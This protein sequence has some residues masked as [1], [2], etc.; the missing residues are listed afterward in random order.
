MPSYGSITYTTVSQILDHQYDTVCSLIGAAVTSTTASRTQLRLFGTLDHPPATVVTGDARSA[1]LNVEALDLSS[2]KLKTGIPLSLTSRT[3]STT[4][5]SS[6]GGGGANKRMLSPASSLDLFMEVKQQKRVKEEKMFGQIVE[7]LSAVEL[8]KCYLAEDG[9]PGSEMQAFSSARAPDKF[10][11]SSRRN[12]GESVDSA[13][14]SSGSPPFSTAP[15]GGDAEDGKV[16][17]DTAAQPTSSDDPRP[18]LRPSQFPSLRTATGV[19]WCYLNYAKPSSV[20][21]DDAGPAPS[22]YATWCVSL[23]NPNPPAVSTSTA[24]A[25]LRCPAPGPLPRDRACCSGESESRAAID[26]RLSVSVKLERSI[27]GKLT[28]HNPSAC[29]PLVDAIVRGQ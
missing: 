20:L 27:M 1:S 2:A 15:V 24:L 18:R 28:Q 9:R 13:M 29:G 22:V 5:A 14:D 4:N 11:G 7:E 8:G 17:M 23:H 16:P 25:L 3:I 21:G 19:S 12:V 26:G 6:G 10:I